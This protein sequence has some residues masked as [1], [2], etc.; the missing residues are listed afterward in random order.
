MRIVSIPYLSYSDTGSNGKKMSWLTNHIFGSSKSEDDN[1]DEV[2]SSTTDQDTVCAMTNEQDSTKNR[3]ETDANDPETL[4]EKREV[5]AEWQV[6]LRG[7]LHKIEFEH[8]TTSG[9]RVLW[10]DKQV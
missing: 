4:Y 8:G 1:K 2:P 7:K 10:I 6:P 9:K 5:A 3:T